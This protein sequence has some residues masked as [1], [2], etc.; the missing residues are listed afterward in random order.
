MLYFN[1]FFHARLSILPQFLWRVGFWGGAIRIIAPRGEFGA[2]ALGR[3]NFKK[4]A[5]IGLYRGFSFDKRVTWHA[6]SDHEAADIRSVW[7]DQS[8]IL[9]SQNETMLPQVAQAPPAGPALGGPVNAVFLGRLV[10]HKGLLIALGALSRVDQSVRLNIYG[11]EEDASYV[12][13][14]RTAARALPTN[15]E[16][17]FWGPIQPADVRETLSKHDVLVM[18]TAGENFG[19]VIAESLSVSCPVI[20][21]DNTPWS[22]VLRGGGGWVV[23]D[24]TVEAWVGALSAYGEYSAVARSL[25]RR[26]AGAAYEEWKVRTAGPHLFSMFDQLCDSQVER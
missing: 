26:R 7:G 16:V 21:S 14:C 17:K 11:A 1:S 4:R 24:R 19:H 22:E 9:I 20:C 13:D 5:F 2:G 3:R 25:H 10:E 12:A 8:R 23:S 18:P 15:V 6:S